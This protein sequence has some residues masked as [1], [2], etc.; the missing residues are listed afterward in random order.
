MSNF[1]GDQEG[2][3]FLIGQIAQ[4]VG[5]YYV[6]L[7]QYEEACE[8]YQDALASYGQVLPSSADFSAA[9]QNR[10]I[11]NRTLD[12]LQSKL[13]PTSAP[14][15]LVKLVQWL[16]HHFDQAIEAGWQAIDTLLAPEQEQL[17]FSLRSS[18]QFREG[19]KR[20]KL[21]EIDKTTVVL[22][23]ALTPEVN[24]EVQVLV[25]V[26]PHQGEILVPGGLELVLSSVDGEVLQTVQA[27]TQDN[28]IQL[29]RFTCPIGEQFSLQ[30]GRDD[31]NYTE[32]F[33]I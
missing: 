26:H 24:Q 33:E 13:T 15:H 3:E 18:M 20:A 30:L 12:S 9:E 19:T 4:T 14:Q 22:L 17:A 25:Q 2:T 16:Q 10:A 1:A 6:Q 23:I 32:Q 28:F 7:E 27:R 8:E 21:V 5:D 31:D 11:V 29:K